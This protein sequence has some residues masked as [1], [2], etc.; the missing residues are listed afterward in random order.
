MAPHSRVRW[1]NGPCRSIPRLHSCEG[2]IYVGEMGSE[3]F[4]LPLASVQLGHRHSMSS[5]GSN[6]FKCDVILNFFFDSW[7]TRK[8]DLP[9]WWKH[10]T[11]FTATFSA[12]AF[13]LI[14]LNSDW[15]RIPLFFLLSFM[16]VFTCIIWL[17]NT[18]LPVKPPN[19]C[20]FCTTPLLNY[21]LMFFD[22]I[23]SLFCPGRWILYIV[24]LSFSLLHVHG[25]FLWLDS[26]LPSCSAPLP[27]ICPL[28]L[29]FTAR[30]GLLHCC[31]LHM[32]K[33]SNHWALF[34]SCCRWPCNL[35]WCVLMMG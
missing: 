35:L 31:D 19:H 26:L 12:V 22:C 18:H 9:S 3:S 34:Q 11:F 24:T 2:Q 4:L 20:G 10:W 5:L 15:N 17:L 28:M 25:C 8:T 1:C 27:L 14:S 29:Y 7:E 33:L 32:I 6:I 23:K 30:P 16:G 21:Q 13:L